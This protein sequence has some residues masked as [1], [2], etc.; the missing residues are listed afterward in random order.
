MWTLRDPTYGGRF[1]D[2]P[3]GRKNTASLVVY[4]L[5]LADR[6]QRERWAPAQQP[7]QLRIDRPCTDCHHVDRAETSGKKHTCP[8]LASNPT[9]RCSRCHQQSP[10]PAERHD[11]L[12][13]QIRGEIFSCGTCHFRQDDGSAELLQRALAGQ[14]PED[15][16]KRTS[17][18][19]PASQ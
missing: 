9:L 16:G 18:T 7:K 4:S 10:V 11:A 8:A 3:V 12:C 14:S 2:T 17:A 19:Q 1:A 6:I 15:S 5:A 13:P